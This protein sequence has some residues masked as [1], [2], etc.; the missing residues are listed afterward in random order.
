M[1]IRRA[2]LKRFLRHPGGQ[3]AVVTVLMLIL[4]VL[5]GRGVEFAL[6]VLFGGHWMVF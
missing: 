3:F 5:V 1:R 2:R 4:S 6:R